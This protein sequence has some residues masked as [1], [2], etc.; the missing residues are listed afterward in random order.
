MRVLYPGRIEIW[1]CWFLWR[2]ENRGTQ[3]K[4]LGARREPTTNSTHMWL[5]AGFEP[6]PH[7]WEG[8]T[9]TN[10]PSL[11]TFR[12]D[13]EPKFSQFCSPLSESKQAHLSGKQEAFDQYVDDL[14]FV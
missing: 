3:R 7:W 12:L 13:L 5:Q 14:S 2:E 8:R 4:S 11:S 1:K 6:W 9:L 10:V